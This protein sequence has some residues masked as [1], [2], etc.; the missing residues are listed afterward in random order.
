MFELL[1]NRLGE[2]GFDL[3]FWG[4]FE[5]GA[6]DFSS[7]NLIEKSAL[8]NFEP[9]CIGGARY[10]TVCGEMGALLI[11]EALHLV[12]HFLRK[13]FAGQHTVPSFEPEKR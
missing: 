4:A 9:L 3:T 2:S 12:D 11:T 13:S 10:V 5:P 1:V 8:H 6:E 7:P